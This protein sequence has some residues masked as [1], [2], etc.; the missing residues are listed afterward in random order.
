MNKGTRKRIAA[1]RIP[2]HRIT[3]DKRTC[4]TKKDNIVTNDLIN[5]DPC[6]E[7]Q[8]WCAMKK[9]SNSLKSW[10]MWEMIQQVLDGS[11]V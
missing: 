4:E 6:W 11:K 3:K 5:F 7:P 2:D 8:G 1:A 10:K 9:K